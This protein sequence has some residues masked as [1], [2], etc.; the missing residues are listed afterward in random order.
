MNEN[1]KRS[2]QSLYNANK[3][4]LFTLRLILPEY[5]AFNEYC[6]NINVNRSAYVKKLIN[7]DATK[8]GYKPIF[9]STRDSNKNG[10][11]GYI[12]PL[13]LANEII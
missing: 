1:S 12:K 3:T 4:K 11:E 8:R 13:Y 10:I 9:G 5:D 6:T 7:E 2:R